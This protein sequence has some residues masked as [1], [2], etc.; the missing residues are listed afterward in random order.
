MQETWVRFLGWEDPLEQEMA[1]H[2]SILAWRIP[3]TAEPGRL[4][5]MR[6][7]ESDTTSNQTHTH[8]WG[9]GRPVAWTPDPEGARE[10]DSVIT[11]GLSA[12]APLVLSS[13]LG[14]QVR[15][16]QAIFLT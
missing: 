9:I 16:S 2:S 10:D 8:P 5:S 7:Q 14:V 3:R 12:Q 13:A 15:T 6:L 11:G 4:Q 1:T